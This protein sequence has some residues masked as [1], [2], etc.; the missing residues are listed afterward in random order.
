MREYHELG[1]MEVEVLCVRA[2]FVIASDG[3]MQHAEM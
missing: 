1:S 2:E 3:S